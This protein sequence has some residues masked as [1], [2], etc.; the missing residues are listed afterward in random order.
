[1]RVKMSKPPPTRTYCKCNRPLPYCNQNCRTPRHW[2]VTQ[3]HRTT[4]PP[5]SLDLPRTPASKR[6]HSLSPDHNVVNMENKFAALSEVR[7]S[8][9]KAKK[10]D[11]EDS[12]DIHSPKD[13]SDLE[14]FTVVNGKKT[15]KTTPAFQGKNRKCTNWQRQRVYIRCLHLTHRPILWHKTGRDL[16][17][18]TEGPFKRGTQ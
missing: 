10:L 18:V 3:H 8:A 6:K 7:Q 11:F 15:R 2:K 16:N 5:P 13:H 9:K 14:G 1:M 4:R 12:E 17:K